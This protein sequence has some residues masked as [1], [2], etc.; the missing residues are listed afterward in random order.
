LINSPSR[1]HSQH[2]DSSCNTFLFFD[3]VHLLKNIRNNLLNS[4]N[5]VFPAFSFSINDVSISSED[6]YIT[7][8]NI[9]E[10]HDLDSHLKAN[11]HKAPKLTYQS[12]HPG[13][14]KQNVKLALSIFD[15]TTI[16]A[17]KSFF[18]DRSDVSAFLTLINHWWKISNSKLIYTPSP[19]CNAVVPDDGKVAFMEAMA[20]WIERWS[21]SALTFCFSKQTADAM[22]HTLKHS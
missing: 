13:N 4:K 3:S 16:A 9:H 11:L 17:C 12:L 22:V 21:S 8:R 7:W 6:G 1:L 15:D 5:F 18:L 10:I 2:P 14:K 19:L 20:T